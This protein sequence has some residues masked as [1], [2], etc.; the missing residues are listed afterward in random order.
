MSS[1]AIKKNNSPLENI[2]RDHWYFC[3][4]L[5]KLLPNFSSDKFSYETI[6]NCLIQFLPSMKISGSEITNA[7]LMRIY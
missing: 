4:N 5:L 7:E 6:L 2:W 1:Y 3:R